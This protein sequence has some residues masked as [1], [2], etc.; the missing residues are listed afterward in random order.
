MKVNIA[1]ARELVSEYEKLQTSLTTDLCN[2]HGE[3][4]DISEEE[5]DCIVSDMSRFVAMGELLIP[6][7]RYA[8]SV[9]EENGD[10]VETQA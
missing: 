3:L 2:E 7:V 9:A 4:D 1:R 6:L 5:A 8:I 10:A